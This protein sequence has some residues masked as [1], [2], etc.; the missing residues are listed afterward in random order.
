M[1]KTEK[2][3]HGSGLPSLHANMVPTYR[4]HER[5][6]HPSPPPTDDTHTQVDRCYSPKSIEA[7]GS[8]DMDLSYQVPP[9][10]HSLQKAWQST[11]QSS[12]FLCAALALCSVHIMSYS[13]TILP[14]PDAFSTLMAFSYG[15]I[16]FNCTAAVASLVLVD[17]IGCVPIWA[18]RRSLDPP[19]AGWM[20]ANIDIL[21]RFGIGSS[22]RWIVWYWI[23]NLCA[24]FVCVVVQVFML[25]W[26]QEGL[27]SLKVVSSV[28]LA[29]S[30]IPLVMFAFSSLVFAFR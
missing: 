8:N 20:S 5:R 25:V 17:K 29:T 19:N 9:L 18:A 21:D 14:Q 7:Q 22:W 23:V 6:L 15:G 27:T 16:I 26:L 12:L 24:G 2:W 3:A 4:E 1:S 28:L 30:S 10:V 13:Q 11:A